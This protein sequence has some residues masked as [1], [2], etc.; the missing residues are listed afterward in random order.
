MSL[1]RLRVAL[2]AAFTLVAVAAT[3]AWAASPRTGSYG[4]LKYGIAFKVVKTDA[5][6]RI[7][8]LSGTFKEKCNSDPLIVKGRIP[9]RGGRFR[10]EGQADSVFGGPGARLLFRGRF[11][12]KTEARG[13][14]QVT[15]GSCSTGRVRYAA[16]RA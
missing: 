13:V 8:Q 5:G 4:N 11:T 16:K 1:S 9:I 2:I 6:K 10:F 12:S 3:L 15:K 7:A 14:F